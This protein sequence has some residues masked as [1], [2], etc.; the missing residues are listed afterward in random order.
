MLGVGSCFVAVAL[1]VGSIRF[2][3]LYLR[4][5]FLATPS[6][7]A[8]WSRRESAVSCLLGLQIRIPPGHGCLPLVSAVSCHLEV[9]RRADRSSR[10]VLPRVVCLSAIVKPL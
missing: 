8:A 3:K 10:G 9:L 2:L 7:V 4:K 5:K 6:P 1:K